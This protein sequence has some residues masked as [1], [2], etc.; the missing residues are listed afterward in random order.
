MD[1]FSLSV[2]FF[3]VE[4]GDIFDTEDITTRQC[5]EKPRFSPDPGFVLT[6]C[7]VAPI[8]FRSKISPFRKF[9]L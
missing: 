5:G 4:E 7:S 3:M 8:T 9:G 2:G 1:T 6:D